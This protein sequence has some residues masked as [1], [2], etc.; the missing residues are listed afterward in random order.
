MNLAGIAMLQSPLIIKG[1]NLFTDTN[2]LWFFR[3]W[4]SILLRSSLI[5]FKSYDLEVNMSLSGWF[6]L[7]H[8]QN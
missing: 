4:L 3:R 6:I 2:S 5:F 7:V 1:D 8:N